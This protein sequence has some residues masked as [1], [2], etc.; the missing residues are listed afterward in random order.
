MSQALELPP[1]EEN[2]FEEFEIEFPFG[3]SAGAINGINEELVLLKAIDSLRSPAGLTKTGSFTWN[4]Q[5]GNEPIYGRCYYHNPITG[6]TVNCMGMPN[7]GYKRAAELHP[8]LQKMARHFGKLLIPSISV[9][10]GAVAAEALPKMA[11]AFTSAGA[12]IIEVDYNCSN[13]IRE[14]GSREPVMGYEPDMLFEVHDKVFEE[15]GSDVIIVINLPPY[16]NQYRRLV[17]TVVK[18][19][20]QARG[21]IA[22]NVSNAIGD[23][24]V[25]TEN[26]GPALETPG[27]LGGLSGPA[28]IEIARNQL[29]IFRHALPRRIGIISCNGVFNGQEIFQRV[30]NQGADLTAGVTVFYENETRG[31]SYGETAS[32][33][34]EEYIHAQIST[35]EKAPA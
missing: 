26:G 2:V 7:I 28:T 5:E 27:N 3:P 17:P 31:L 12:S 29:D 19:L 25:Y 16:I 34:A 13:I 10:K 6:E 23:Q 30:H 20:R 33:I 4:R 21:R 24:Q 11:Y 32:R 15:I 1:L 18:G 22:V 8:R 14:D 9:G 35:L